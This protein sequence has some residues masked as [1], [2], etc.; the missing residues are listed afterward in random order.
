M[1][2][3]SPWPHMW[4]NYPSSLLLIPN[5]VLQLLSE[6]ASLLASHLSLDSDPG[7]SLSVSEEWCEFSIVISES[8]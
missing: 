6:I 3:Q 5:L 1:L 8:L 7:V 4:D 2:I